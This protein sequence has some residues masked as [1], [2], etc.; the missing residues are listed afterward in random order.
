MDPLWELQVLQ[1]VDAGILR[2][3]VNALPPD[4]RE[5]VVLRYFMDMPLVQIAKFLSLPV[6][7]VIKA[8]RK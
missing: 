6:G 8:L 7:T 1:A 3:A 4:M 5:A 2:D